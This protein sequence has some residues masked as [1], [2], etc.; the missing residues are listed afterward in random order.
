MQFVLIPHHFVIRLAVHLFTPSR[1]IFKQL[2][3]QSG[4]RAREKLVWTASGLW[5]T[6]QP[7]LSNFG[8]MLQLCLSLGSS[9]GSDLH[10]ELAVV[11]FQPLLH[12]GDIFTVE[13]HLLSVTIWLGLSFFHLLLHISEYMKDLAFI[14][15]RRSDVADCLLRWRGSNVLCSML[16]V[17]YI[18]GIVPPALVLV[19][20]LE[21]IIVDNHLFFRSHWH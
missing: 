21:H 12:S 1:Y 13:N 19:L 17:D 7:S 11:S 10:L 15:W 16:R 14:Q 9:K 3:R 4:L 5:W 18:W 6:H 8:L 2:Y 20:P